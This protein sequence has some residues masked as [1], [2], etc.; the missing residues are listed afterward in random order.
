[1]VRQ[2][3]GPSKALER[4]VH[5]KGRKWYIRGQ[6]LRL[7]YQITREATLHLHVVLLCDGFQQ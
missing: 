2:T 3:L 4:V 1:M 6:W 7:C 5:L